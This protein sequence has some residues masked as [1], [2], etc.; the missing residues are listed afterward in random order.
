LGRQKRGICNLCA[1][2]CGVVLFF[3]PDGAL[4]KVTGDPDD[5]VTK[6]WTCKA[7][8]RFMIEHGFSPESLVADE[9]QPLPAPPFPEFGEGEHGG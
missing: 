9:L 8:R 2:S 1:A 3:D 4:V 5:S 6:G 7:G